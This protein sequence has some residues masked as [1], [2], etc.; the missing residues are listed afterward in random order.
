MELLYKGYSQKLISE[1]R[2]GNK[3]YLNDTWWK[4]LMIQ[5]REDCYYLD[6]E[7]PF[8]GRTGVILDEKIEYYIKR[9]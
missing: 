5:K 1:A 9:S 7:A 4:I 3:I 8:K 6:I 2:I